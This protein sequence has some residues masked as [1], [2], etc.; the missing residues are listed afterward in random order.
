MVTSSIPLSFR[1]LRDTVR[2]RSESGVR[3]RGRFENSASEHVAVDAALEFRAG[4][5]R[6]RGNMRNV[7]RI[8][9]YRVVVRGA[10]RRT[11]TMVLRAAGR[12]LA[13]LAGANLDVR[14]EPV[15]PAGQIIDDPMVEAARNRSVWVVHHDGERVGAVRRAAPG[16]RGRAVFASRTGVP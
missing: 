4:E 7:Q 2:H 11:R 1:R 5:R 8:H 12:G 14:F 13:E 6:C 3:C 9:R 16:K 15:R 10:G